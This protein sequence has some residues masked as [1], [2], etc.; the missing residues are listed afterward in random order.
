MDP[1]IVASVA[2]VLITVA[3][4]ACVLPARRAANTDPLIALSDQ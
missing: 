1:A 3:F 2:A 4:V